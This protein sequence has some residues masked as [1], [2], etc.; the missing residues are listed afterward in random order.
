MA[1]IPQVGRERETSRVDVPAVVVV[2]NLEM[3]KSMSRRKPTPEQNPW[4]LSD[5]TP[6]A[7]RARLSKKTLAAYDTD[8]Q[9]FREWCAEQGVDA[10]PAAPEHIVEYLESWAGT[11]LAYKTVLRKRTAI[12]A[13]HRC[14]GYD[15]PPTAASTVTDVLRRLSDLLPHTTTAMPLTPELLRKALPKMGEG[16]LLWYRDRSILT[17][18]V[19]GGLS[20]VEL[21]GL[22]LD[23]VELVTQGLRIELSDR[24]IGICHGK[25]KLTDPVRA[26]TEW[27]TE[28]GLELGAQGFLFRTV[29]RG[30]FRPHQ[31]ING[32]TVH[33]TIKRAATA[34]DEDPSVYSGHSL[35]TGFILAA[36]NAGKPIE[37]VLAHTGKLQPITGQPANLFRSNPSKDIGL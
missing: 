5:S 12:A 23:Q 28:T 15:P 18:G 24:T 11:H 9:E 6:T 31:T 16:T 29:L 2:E 8:W 25:R 1:S 10:L 17:L 3:L 13:A 35:R 37:R 32:Q 36:T 7:F 21:A 14:Q 4:E 26:L 34:G 33:R 19:A 22:Q 20:P 30:K 27:L